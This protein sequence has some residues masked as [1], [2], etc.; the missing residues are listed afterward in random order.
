[1]RIGDEQILQ[2]MVNVR[3]FAVFRVAR[4][5]VAVDGEREVAVS[6]PGVQRDRRDAGF[7]DRLAPGGKMEVRRRLVMSARLQPAPDDDVVDQQ[8][9]PQVRRDDQCARGE[10]SGQG[11]ALVE[12][13]AFLQLPAQQREV[14]APVGDALEISA[15]DSLE[16]RQDVL[17]HQRVTPTRATPR[18]VSCCRASVWSRCLARQVRS[19]SAISARTPM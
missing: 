4:D 16:A 3:A 17:G 12:A 14:F 5:V 8:H 13:V 10:V 15:Q 7:L 11:C 9:L 1:M 6:V 18:G 2:V 19:R